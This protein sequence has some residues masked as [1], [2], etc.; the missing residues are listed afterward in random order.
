MRP[1]PLCTAPE[2]VTV[3]DHRAKAL[4]VEGMPH[5]GYLRA[6]LSGATLVVAR[7]ENRLARLSRFAEDVPA[8][9]S[10]TTVQNDTHNSQTVDE[11][12][13]GL[14]EA[15][16]FDTI[17]YTKEATTWFGRSK[18]FHRFTEER[19]ALG[20]TVL[21]KTKWVPDSNRLELEEIVLVNPLRFTPPDVYLRWSKT[22][23]QQTL[24]EAASQ[25]ATDGGSTAGSLNGAANS[26]ESTTDV[27]N[28][29][30][31]TDERAGTV[32]KITWA[33]ELRSQFDSEAVK[34]EFTPGWSWHT[35]LI[36]YVRDR[37]E[38]VDGIVANLCCGSNTLG[39]V[40]VDILREYEQDGSGD[41]DAATAT[42]AATVQADVTAT[43]LPT[44]SVQ[45]VVTDPPWKIS[46]EQ[47]LRL[48]SEAVRIVEPG[49]Q[50]IVN[51]WWLP[52]HP[53]VTVAGPI[54]AVTA[55]V[56]DTS[57]NGPGGLSFLTEY[58]V[59]EHPNHKHRE[60]TLTDHMERVGVE[61]MESYF[62]TTQRGPG[63]LDDPRIDPRI[64][65]ASTN[66]CEMCEADSFVVRTARGVPL[67][68]CRRCGFRH[69]ADELLSPVR[70]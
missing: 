37:L 25:P 23:A 15:A 3:L 29:I 2:L 52:N 69:A 31:P 44:N 38:A 39:D 4:S 1:T 28:G 14:S 24:A 53:Y 40:R 67:Y 58:E 49:G 21:G 50:V 57:L 16:Q 35:E 36:E 18:D 63:P 34:T 17:V 59:A 10:V 6:H 13:L 30:T 64:I 8:V 11:H 12:D 9:E 66:G 41:S 56:D 65:G 42:T 48:F 5:G 46:I 20:G 33:R 61:G 27:E 43:P 54:R 19:L 62:S 32:E 55:N 7:D 22:A 26:R 68:E 51:A 60:Y 47:R 45:A 70:R